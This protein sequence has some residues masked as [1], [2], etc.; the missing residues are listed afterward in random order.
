[1]HWECWPSAH[2]C[3]LCFQDLLL[4]ISCVPSQNDKLLQS[5]PNYMVVEQHLDHNRQLRLE[6]LLDGRGQMISLYQ[7]LVI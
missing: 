1:M 2:V 6:D 7:V 4:Q 3:V 5:M